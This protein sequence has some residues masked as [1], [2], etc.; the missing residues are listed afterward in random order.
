MKEILKPQ[1][2]LLL[3]VLRRGFWCNAY[4][5]LFGVGVSFC[6]LYSMV[7]YLYVSCSVSFTS[8]GEERANLSAI[9]KL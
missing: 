1:G 2:S 8:V 7:S 5:K 9:F 4:L 3:T 6:I